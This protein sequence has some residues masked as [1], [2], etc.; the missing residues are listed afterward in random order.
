MHPLLSACLKKNANANIKRRNLALSRMSSITLVSDMK[1]DT[2]SAGCLGEIGRITL[3]IGSD[4]GDRRQVLTSSA[5]ESEVVG[6]GH[7]GTNSNQN[8]TQ[9]DDESQVP[10]TQQQL[11][12][13]QHGE[14]H[15]SADND[16]QLTQEIP[17]TQENAKVLHVKH[18]Q[19][20]LISRFPA[21]C[22][23]M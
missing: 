17:A 16:S 5:S 13:S 20:I 2:S 12:E 9:R 6:T 11:P 3:D 1:N 18:T 10:A 8:N 22:E 15:D 14:E 23:F 19:H 7:S 4:E 21:L